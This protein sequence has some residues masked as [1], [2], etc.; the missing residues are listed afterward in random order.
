MSAANLHRRR[1][2]HQRRRQISIG[3]GSSYI[4]G[5]SSS[6][7]ATSSGGGYSWALEATSGDLTPLR[8]SIPESDDHIGRSEYRLKPVPS[9]EYGFRFPA[10]IPSAP[11]GIQYP[12]GYQLPKSGRRAPENRF[13]IFRRPDRSGNRYRHLDGRTLHPIPM[14]GRANPTSLQLKKCLRFVKKENQI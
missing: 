11:N 6:A 12:L 9:T 8:R 13:R 2:L 5:G 3:G 14:S 7:A 1:Q 4:N 10:T